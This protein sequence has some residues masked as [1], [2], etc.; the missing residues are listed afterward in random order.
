LKNDEEKAL[1]S[2]AHTE[3]LL[4]PST[5]FIAAWERQQQIRGSEHLVVYDQHKAKIRKFGNISLN[6][7]WLEYF[8]RMYIHNLLFPDIE[9]ELLGFSEYMGKLHAVLE[10]AVVVADTDQPATADEI[11]EHL[12]NLGFQPK[13]DPNHRGKITELL[14][15]STMYV[16]EE[17]GLIIKDTVSKNVLKRSVDGKL[18]FIDTLITFYP[19]AKFELRLNSLSLSCFRDTFRDTS[20][21]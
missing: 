16:C 11:T 14:D 2:W 9:Y 17:L 3:G 18:S 20:V 1:H 6:N 12:K 5:S 21:L 8:Q 15:S 7:T 4:L 13:L 19:S 10:Q